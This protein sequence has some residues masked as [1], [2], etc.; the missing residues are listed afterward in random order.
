MRGVGQKTP[1]LTI[2]SF[3]TRMR[4][5]FRPSGAL[6]LCE[7]ILPCWPC[8]HPLSSGVCLTTVC[9]IPHMARRPI[10]TAAASPLLPKPFPCGVTAVL[11]CPP[12]GHGPGNGARAPAPATCVSH[13]GTI[14]T[15]W[16]AAPARPGRASAA[17]W[18]SS[19]PP[20]RHSPRLSP[21]RRYCRASPRRHRCGWL[22]ASSMPSSPAS[23][24]AA[25][26]SLS[27]PSWSSPSSSSSCCSA[28][29]S[30]RRPAISANNCCRS[31]L[32]STSSSRSCA[33]PPRSIWPISRTPPTTTSCSRRSANRRG[34]RWRWSPAS[35]ASAARSS[36]SPRWSP[37]SSA[38]RPGWRPPR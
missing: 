36:P 12:H 9:S 18:R 4:S 5:C 2:T 29:A 21:V 6:V 32:P 26:T 10:A 34:G 31:G 17:S 37:S 33:T 11:L 27:A 16:P 28:P 7:E 14:C 22:A 25:R 20:A 3:P 38:C 13:G 8:A 1:L 30:C 19:G 35:S 24:R 15:P 23:P